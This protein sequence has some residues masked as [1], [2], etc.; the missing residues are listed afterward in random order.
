M[1]QLESEISAQNEDFNNNLPTLQPSVNNIWNN[2]NLNQVKLVKNTSSTETLDN[3]LQ[4]FPLP[5][6]SSTAKTASKRILPVS[7]TP[8]ILP[9][10]V[11]RR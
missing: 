8:R 11:G 4:R 7:E 5:A 6:I 3:V 9:A 1:Q 2:L 10:A